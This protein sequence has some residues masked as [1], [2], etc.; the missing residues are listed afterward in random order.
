ME[1]FLGNDVNLPLNKNYRLYHKSK[2]AVVKSLGNFYS[3]PVRTVSAGRA[4]NYGTCLIMV[5]KINEFFLRKSGKKF[6]MERYY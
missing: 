1:F 3:I 2:K 5:G 6:A 4:L